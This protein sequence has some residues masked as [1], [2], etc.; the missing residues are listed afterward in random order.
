MT[1]PFEVVT[2]SSAHSLNEFFAGILIAAEGVAG[3]GVG[4]KHRIC[5]VEIHTKGSE[6]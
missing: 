4:E 5:E 6:V 2:A 1:T 3:C